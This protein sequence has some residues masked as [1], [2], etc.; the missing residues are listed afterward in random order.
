MPLLGGVSDAKIDAHTE[1]VAKFAVS[2]LN[3]KANFPKEGT[4]ELGKVVSAK[5]QVVAGIN[6]ILT[7]ETKDTSGTTKTVEVTVWEKVSVARY[8]QLHG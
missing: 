7:I 6:H 1:D 2:Q 4:L 5:T 8:G 3:G